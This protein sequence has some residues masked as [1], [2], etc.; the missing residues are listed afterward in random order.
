MF[1]GSDQR[2]VSRLIEHMFFKFVKGW[3]LWQVEF[4]SFNKIK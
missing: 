2:N 3:G 4:F 1:L